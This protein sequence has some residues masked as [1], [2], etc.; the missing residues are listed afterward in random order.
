MKHLRLRHK[1]AGDDLRTHRLSPKTVL[2]FFDRGRCRHPRWSIG[3]GGAEFRLPLLLS[4]FGYV[5]LPAMVVNLVVSLVTVIFSFLF[6]LRTIGFDVIASN[7]SVVINIL[8][9]SLMGS[10]SGGQLAAYIGERA[11]RRMVVLLLVMFSLLL[12]IHELMP[13]SGI[14]PLNR[15]LKVVLGCLAGL[16]IGAVSSLLGVAGGELIIPAIVLLLAIDIKLAASLSLA[17]SA[18]TLLMGL[19]RYQ[20]QRQLAHVFK[21]R[22]FMAGMALDSI[23]DS[24]VG[25]YILRHIADLYLHFFLGRIPA[26]FGN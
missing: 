3:L 19:Y 26:G 6:R 23:C 7:L 14:G 10:Y 11:L 15:L 4:V 21:D 1:V 8:S 9:G 5:T 12:M 24:L 20:R 2:I 25:S 13:D 17:I 16:A 22:A 18:P